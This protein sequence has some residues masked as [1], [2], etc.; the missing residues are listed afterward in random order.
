MTEKET[1]VSI[2]LLINGKRVGLNPYVT[3]V[4]VNVIRGLVGS[5]KNVGEPRDIEI[6]VVERR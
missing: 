2:E 1:N 6:K 4:F 5:L 3:S